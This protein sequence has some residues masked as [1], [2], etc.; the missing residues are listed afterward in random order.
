[1]VLLLNSSGVLLLNSSGV[2]L[3]NVNNSSSSKVSMMS[4][5]QESEQMGGM[6]RRL[7]KINISGKNKPIKFL[8]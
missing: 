4:E 5:P 8:I 2:L 6:V 3:D 1:M 7:N